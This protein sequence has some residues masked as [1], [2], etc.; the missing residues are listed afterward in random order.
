MEETTKEPDAATVD[1]RAELAKARRAVRDLPRNGLSTTLEAYWEVCCGDVLLAEEHCEERC[2][3]WENSALAAEFL[4]IAAYLEQYDHLLDGLRTASSR[5][6]AAVEY[7]PRL[8]VR[9][10]RFELQVLRRIEARC[11]HDLDLCDD[12]LHE[13]SHLERNIEQADRGAFD[14]VEPSGHLR[15][16]PVEWSADYERVIDEVLHRVDLQLADHPRGLGFCFA[17]WQAKKRVL[18]DDYGIEWHS[19][20]ELNPGVLFD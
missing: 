1:Y 7:H 16:D 17:F 6:A 10:L 4:D 11:P 9:L 19:P 12:V 2:G 3:M 8:K 20:S 13:L 14:R 5:L 15:Q 18:R